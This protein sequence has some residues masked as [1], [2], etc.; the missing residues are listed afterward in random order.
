MVFIDLNILGDYL[1]EGIMLIS[2][3]RCCNLLRVGAL[4]IVICSLDLRSV[5]YDC[6]KRVLFEKTSGLN[7]LVIFE[8]L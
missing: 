5:K 2:F 4:I 3:F 8:K 7:K 6:S 1:D